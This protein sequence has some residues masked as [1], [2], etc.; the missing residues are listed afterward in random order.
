MSKVT[1]RDVLMDFKQR[2]PN[3]AK[4][5]VDYRPYDYGTIIVYLNDGQTMLY[6]Y[7]TKRGR[8]HDKWK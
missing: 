5:V 7:T 4:M 1:W 6:D 8:F 3:L 2:H